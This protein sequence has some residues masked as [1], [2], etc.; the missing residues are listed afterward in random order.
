MKPEDILK[1]NYDPLTRKFRHVQLYCG[2]V[3]YISK[4]E[5]QQLLRKLYIVNMNESCIEGKKDGGIML[6]TEC[7]DQCHSTSIYYDN[8]LA[9]HSCNLKTGKSLQ[10]GNIK[11]YLQ[12]S[13]DTFHKT[14]IRLIENGYVDNFDTIVISKPLGAQTF[15]FDNRTKKE[16]DVDKSI[17][18]DL[19]AFA[20]KI[21]NSYTFVDYDSDVKLWKD[22]VEFENF[23]KTTNQPSSLIQSYPSLIQSS[24]IQS[25]PSPIQ[26]SSSPIQ[27]SQPQIQLCPS[28]IQSYQ[29]PVIIPQTI[30]NPIIDE[31][32]EENLLKN[33][34]IKTD[35][36]LVD[37][38][39]KGTLYASTLKRAIKN[40]L[41]SLNEYQNMAI[42]NNT[43]VFRNKFFF[44]NFIS[45]RCNNYTVLDDFFCNFVK[46][47]IIDKLAL[48]EYNFDADEYDSVNLGPDIKS[49]EEFKKSKEG[50]LR[51]ELT[52]DIELP[53][54]SSSE[55]S[56][57]IPSEEPSEILSE[58]IPQ[59]VSSEEQTSQNVPSEEG[60]IKSELEITIPG[61]DDNGVEEF[62]P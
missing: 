49:S 9:S 61:G 37:E 39:K 28:P 56:R 34:K 11:E 44:M 26:S 27:S 35:I 30:Q 59:E 3:P 10:H 40:V 42:L 4:N 60:G 45:D 33:I 62:L 8:G 12:K 23:L 18:K 19:I 14:V 32:S 54:G 31:I 46:K 52:D 22:A 25:S 55:Q 21:A 13:P 48:T 57:Q 50:L 20:G 41:L 5:K 36:K 47:Y 16:K 43:V 17:S 15:Y 6:K 58:Q 7:K 2:T 53:V 51:E 29:Q 38:M 24:S 1:Y